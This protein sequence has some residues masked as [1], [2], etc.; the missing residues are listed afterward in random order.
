MDQQKILFRGGFSGGFQ[1]FR[2]IYFISRTTLGSTAARFI[3]PLLRFVMRRFDN[4]PI[5]DTHIYQS[6]NCSQRLL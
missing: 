4:L 5:A 1:V 2:F 3:R 6:D